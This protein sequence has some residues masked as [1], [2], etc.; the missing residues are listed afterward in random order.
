MDWYWNI[1]RWNIALAIQSNRVY[2]KADGVDWMER[3]PGQ[4]AFG[5]ARIGRRLAAFVNATPPL[6]MRGVGDFWRWTDAGEIAYEK[7]AARRNASV[8]VR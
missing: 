5:T 1:D 3:P 8:T 7:E 4:F 6:I 2:R